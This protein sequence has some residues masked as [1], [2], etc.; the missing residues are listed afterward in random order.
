MD[1]KKWIFAPL[2]CVGS[3]V[4]TGPR[5]TVPR[6]SADRYPAHVDQKNGASIGA[7]MLTPGQVKKIFAGDL[8][9]CCVVVEVALYP[10]KDGLLQV[11]MD[12]FVLREAGKDIGAKPST[13]EVL[14][15]TLQKEFPPLRSQPAQVH[16]SVG[17]SIGA[18]NGRTAST[19]GE[20][21]IGTGG[22]LL[23]PTDTG[24]TDHE[25]RI[26]QDDLQEK[27]LPEG[28]ASAPVAGD[29]YFLMKRKKKTKYELV[30]TTT[31]S[32]LVLAL[33]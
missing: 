24:G 33:P 5:G 31:G 25:R 6:T 8:N 13:A 11:S 26:I 7:A 12:D 22:S 2:V 3:L 28:K 15:V 9:S 29:L 21:R 32:K 23:P 16:G 18:G 19:E 14:A 17:G 27:G 10:Q 4:A 30:Y 20:L 1:L